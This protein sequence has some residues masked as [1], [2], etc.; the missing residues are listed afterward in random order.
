MKVEI[1]ISEKRLSLSRQ[2]L[3]HHFP[4]HAWTDESVCEVMCRMGQMMTLI[5]RGE[6]PDSVLNEETFDAALERLKDA[7]MKAITSMDP[8]TLFG[9]LRPRITE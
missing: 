2:A 1:E 4:D 3:E 9:A 6:I 5:P 7:L 8:A